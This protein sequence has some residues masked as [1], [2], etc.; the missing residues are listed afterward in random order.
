MNRTDVHEQQPTTDDSA[1]RAGRIRQEEA[2]HARGRE[3]AHLREVGR[4]LG[5]QLQEQI[6]KRPY[7]VLGAAAGAGFVLGS[8]LGSRLGQVLIAASLGYAAKN[9]IEGNLDME[10]IEQRIERLAKERSTG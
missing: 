7:V 10:R 3:M 5:T 2:A 4:N 6:R 1:R 8:L 9:A